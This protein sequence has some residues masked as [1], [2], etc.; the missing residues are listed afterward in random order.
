MFISTPDC[1][2]RCKSRWVVWVACSV[3]ASF[4]EGFGLIK[5]IEVQQLPQHALSAGIDQTLLRSPAHTPSQDPGP[6][7]RSRYPPH[8][9]PGCAHYSSR[10]L[11]SDTG[12]AT[13]A[14]ETS[15][16]ILSSGDQSA[17]LSAHAESPARQK[18]CQL[19]RRNG[20]R[21]WTSGCCSGG[22]RG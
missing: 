16:R 8:L 18:R 17:K 19:R 1:C 20:R 11:L 9:S 12:A 10:T 21:S 15:R 2:V 4:C 7:S 3:R 6:S 14:S 5:A 13:T 22:R